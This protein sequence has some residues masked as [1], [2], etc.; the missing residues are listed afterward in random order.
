MIVQRFP[1]RR[2]KIVL[3]VFAAAQVG[4]EAKHGFAIAPALSAHCIAGGEKQV[5]S[6]DAQAARRPNAAAARTCFEA[7]NFIGV[8]QRN[9]DH[10][11][12]IISAISV[13]TAE[14]D[15]EGIIEDRKRCALVLDGWIEIAS[16]FLQGLGNVDR[17]AGKDGA[18]LQRKPKHLMVDTARQFDGSVKINRL[19]RWIDDRRA[20]NA[21]RINV[22]AWQ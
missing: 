21:E 17:P 11:A 1:I 6:D 20:G 13:M 10:P 14:G 8:V 9:S 12:V 5:A 7:E 15:E 16:R 22:A 18:I 4:A 3:L 19:C 2:R